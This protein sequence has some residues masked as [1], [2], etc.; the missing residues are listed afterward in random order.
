MLRGFYTAA[1]GMI[2]GG[3]QMETISN[4]VANANTPGF[5]TD[6]AILR[7]FPELLIK[8]MGAHE[9]QTSS[10]GK[11]VGPLHTG[12]FV[13]EVMTDFA[14]GQVRETGMPTDIA[15]VDRELPDENGGLFFT[16]ADENGELRYTRNGHFT[17]DGD[18]FLT[19]NTGYYVLNEEGNHI[20]M[21]GDTFIVTEDGTVQTN[22]G[23]QTKLQISYIADTNTLVKEAN[24]LF[25]LDDGVAENAENTNFSILQHTLEGSNVN[26]LQ[27]MTDMMTTYRTFEQN[28]R[29]LK[30]YD[31]SMGKA[32]NEIARLG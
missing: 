28:Q 25:A 8:Q 21:N 9:A 13:Q 12:V 32:V 15:I 7:S 4:N 19:T 2:A 14:Q 20:E 22:A 27:A 23:G 24:D 1:S 18:G 16:I 10:R 5:K 26:A 30:A 3:R 17:I 29:V 11:T 6:Q 31:E